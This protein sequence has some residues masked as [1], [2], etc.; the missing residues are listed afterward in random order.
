M[1]TSRTPTHGPDNTDN[2]CL[3][4]WHTQCWHQQHLPVDLTH[5][6]DIN[7]TDQGIWHNVDTNIKNQ[8]TWHNAD[9][10]IRPMDLTQTM[11]TLT[12][13]TSGPHTQSHIWYLFLLSQFFLNF[14]INVL[15]G[16]SHHHHYRLKDLTNDVD[17][18]I[19]DQGIWCTQCWHQQHWA[20]DHTHNAE[21][22][23]QPKRSDTE[24]RHQHLTRNLTQNADISTRQ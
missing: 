16:Y 2:T 24:C 3:W 19:T 23:L 15:H 22:T 18:N 1:L 13:Q 17:V 5:N 9:I 12:L 6:A 20:T 8:W 11:L 10:N 7:I 21:S 4:T 14:I